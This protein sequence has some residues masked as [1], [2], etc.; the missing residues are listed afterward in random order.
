MN[1]HCDTCDIEKECDYQ[2][3]PCDCRDKL[4]FVPKQQSAKVIAF[5]QGIRAA[6]TADLKRE[7]SMWMAPGVCEEC[8]GA[9]FHYEDI[10]AELN[11]RGEGEFCAV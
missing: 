7:W 3:K 11:R 10:H 9:K 6:T 2:Y 1:G 8:P 4:K 5:P